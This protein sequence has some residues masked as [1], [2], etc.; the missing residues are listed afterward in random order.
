MLTPWWFALQTEPKIV[1]KMHLAQTG[2]AKDSKEVIMPAGVNVPREQ[3][4][5]F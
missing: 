3:K 2:M 4:K 1:R 5:I